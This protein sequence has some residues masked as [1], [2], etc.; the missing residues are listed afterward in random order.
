MIR[1]HIIIIKYYNYYHRRVTHEHW[2]YMAHGDDDG[3]DNNR[4]WKV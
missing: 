2:K 1:I 4:I 3:A